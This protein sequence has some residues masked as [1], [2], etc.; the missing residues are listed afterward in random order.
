VKSGRADYVAR[1]ALC[2]EIQVD[3][4]SLPFVD[5]GG[6]NDFAQQLIHH[7]HQTDNIP[8]LL[9]LCD[10]LN[11]SVHGTLATQLAAIR[12]KVTKQK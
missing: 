9:R 2:I 6:A 3:T 8:A 10:A 7:L 12:A 4:S 5:L 11:G 1:K